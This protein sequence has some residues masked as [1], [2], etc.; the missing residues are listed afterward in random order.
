MVTLLLHTGLRVSESVGLRLS[1][2]EMSERRGNLAVAGK[3][4]EQRKMPLNA[5][6]RLEATP[7]DPV[8]LTTILEHKSLETLRIYAVPNSVRP[9]NRSERL[10]LSEEEDGQP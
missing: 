8:R 4:N 10:T 1:D 6:A 2:V 7:G 3:R 9:S 5:H